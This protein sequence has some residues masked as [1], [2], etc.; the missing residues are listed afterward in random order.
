[1]IF[2]GTINVPHFAIVFAIVFPVK[3]RINVPRSTQCFIEFITFATGVSLQF[4]N[5]IEKNL[6][7]H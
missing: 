7:V 2:H 5:N 3:I 1:M 4:L 6:S